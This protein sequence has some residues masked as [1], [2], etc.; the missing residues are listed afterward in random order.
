MITI[1]YNT[2]KNAVT[3]L[4]H[5]TILIVWTDETEGEATRVG[6]SLILTWCSAR[7]KS[8]PAARVPPTRSWDRS[9][10]QG[11][12]LVLYPC[13]QHASEALFFRI[14]TRWYFWGGKGCWSKLENIYYA[15]I[16]NGAP[17]E[18]KQYSFRRS[19]Q[20]RSADLQLLPTIGVVQR[21]LGGLKPP[22]HSYFRGD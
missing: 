12:L 14:S 9:S 3:Y 21:G 8:T 15:F 6:K 1:V 22:P 2:H 5:K 16:C 19:S 11:Y 17:I 4:V 7:A 13:M 18:H 10:V 20:K